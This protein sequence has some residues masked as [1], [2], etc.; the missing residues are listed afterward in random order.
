[1]AAATA[2]TGRHHRQPADAGDALLDLQRRYLEAWQGAGQIMVD[3]MQA[4][5]RRQAELAEEAMRELWAEPRDG[6]PGA[7][8]AGG[9]R[10]DRALGL[11]QRAF[12]GFREVGEIVLKAQSD[13]AH[14]LVDG[15]A[16]RP[17]AGR[18]AAA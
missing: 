17:E 16:G 2:E 12:D 14:T 11:Y 1:M 18:K 8:H 10:F 3:A 7:R 9:D 4:V 15:I 13:A 5:A 6:D